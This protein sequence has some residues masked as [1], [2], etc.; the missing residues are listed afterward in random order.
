MHIRP[1]VQIDGR[2][3]EWPPRIDSFRGQPLVPRHDGGAS[4][5]DTDIDAIRP[6]N[7]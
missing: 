1:F 2:D 5:Y 6:L 4:K 7:G 3:S